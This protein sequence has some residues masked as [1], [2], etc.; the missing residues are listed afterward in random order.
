[1]RNYYETVIKQPYRYTVALFKNLNK[2]LYIEK[3]LIVYGWKTRSGANRK[4][5][6]QV[7]VL[8]KN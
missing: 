3:I 1:M 8:N 7:R 6:N 4:K 2:E 5:S